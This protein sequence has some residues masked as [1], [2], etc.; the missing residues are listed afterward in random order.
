MADR[1]I[2]H[3]VIS[4]AENCK[5]VLDNGDELKGVVSID[6]NL[7]HADWFPQVTMKV[8]LSKRL[9]DG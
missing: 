3:L 5:V 6:T 7:I 8:N 1:Y 9:N 4:D 2:E